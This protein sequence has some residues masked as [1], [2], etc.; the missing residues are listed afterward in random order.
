MMARVATYHMTT[1]E[2]V[3]PLENGPTEEDDGP[4]GLYHMKIYII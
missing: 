1:R 3:C 4:G 2:V